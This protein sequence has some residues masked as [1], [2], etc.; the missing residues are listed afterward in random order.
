MLLVQAIPLHMMV[1][2]HHMRVPVHP[3]YQGIT[4][5]AVAD[6]LGLVLLVRLQGLPGTLHRL[7]IQGMSVPGL[8]KV[9]KGTLKMFTQKVLSAGLVDL[10]LVAYSEKLHSPS[11]PLPLVI[12][13]H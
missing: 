11:L 12:Y 2:A 10:H 4:F 6:V 3:L 7:Q 5:R 13:T 9:C 1:S 8:L